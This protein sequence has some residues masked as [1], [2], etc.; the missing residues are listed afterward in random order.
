M[1]YQTKKKMTAATAMTMPKTT[2]SR[3]RPWV[4]AVEEELGEVLTAE[5]GV[6]ELLSKVY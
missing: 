5:S 2:S 6:I 1:R 3:E 4:G